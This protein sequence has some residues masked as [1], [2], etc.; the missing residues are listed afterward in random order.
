VRFFL[1]FEKKKGAHFLLPTSAHRSLGV[2]GGTPPKQISK[3]EIGKI[4][5]PPSLNR[6]NLTSSFPKPKKSHFLLPTSTH[7]SLGFGATPPKQSIRSWY[8]YNKKKREK[9]PHHHLTNHSLGF[10]RRATTKAEHSVTVY[11]VKKNEKD[12][13]FVYCGKEATGDPAAILGTRIRIKINHIHMYKHTHT[14]TII[15]I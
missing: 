15:I 13:F 11:T 2:R 6:K 14:H 5:F 4:S 7:D 1:L 12:F 3:K 9:C 10:Q 8:R